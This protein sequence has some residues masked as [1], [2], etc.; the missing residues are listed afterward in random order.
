M[1]KRGHEVDVF[2]TSINSKESVENYENMTIHRYGTNF[3]VLTSNIS[4]RMFRE[5][6]K[7]YIDIAHT[8]FDIPPGPFTGLWYAKKK[9]VPLVVTYHGDWIESYGGFVR[10]T[11]IAFHNKYLVDKVLSYANVIISPS[12]Y[13]INE[14][15]F[16]RNY[17]DKIIVIPHGI[18]LGDFDIP[19]SKEECRKKLGFRLNDNIRVNVQSY[20]SPRQHC[21]KA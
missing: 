10:R 12:E 11:G 7:H 19:Y 20:L 15:R 13:Y 6:V 16:L 3:R 4:F 18:N 17:R 21:G 2:T 8:H 14:S 9:K 1:R 5:P